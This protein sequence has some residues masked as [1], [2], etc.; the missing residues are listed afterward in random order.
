MPCE[1]DMCNLKYQIS[2]HFSDSKR[3]L[4]QHGQLCD[5]DPDTVFKQLQGVDSQ[6]NASIPR[7]FGLQS[8][9]ESAAKEKADK[10]RQRQEDEKVQIM[11]K[12]ALDREME[13]QKEKADEEQR[14]RLIGR[15]QEE[16]KRKEKERERL[17][18]LER[19]K[20]KAL[21]EEERKRDE[22]SRM[23]QQAEVEVANMRKMEREK[24]IA[25]EKQLTWA[26]KREEE[27]KAQEIRVFEQKER[28]LM[29]F[30]EIVQKGI[31]TTRKSRALNIWI[32]QMIQRIAEDEKKVSTGV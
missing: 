22:A 31:R 24:E 18:H 10:E 7:G 5:D 8:S 4:E 30:C 26:Q 9:S 20:A 12:A 28:K 25:K 21:I 2:I 13:K 17:E 29:D 16:E 27:R 1:Y 3:G 11:K 6:R 15:Q 14:Q 23:K 19:V 32:Q